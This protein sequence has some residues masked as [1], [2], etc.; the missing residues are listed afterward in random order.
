MII[1]IDDGE[2]HL[3]LA[4]LKIYHSYIL[5]ISLNII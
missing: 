1:T 3:I 2:D 5:N 4:F